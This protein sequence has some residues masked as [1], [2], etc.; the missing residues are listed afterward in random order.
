MGT[1]CIYIVSN[2]K[3]VLYIYIYIKVKIIL[4]MRTDTYTEI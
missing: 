2:G 4:N 3:S 1:I